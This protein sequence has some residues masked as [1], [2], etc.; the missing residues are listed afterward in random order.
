M[1]SQNEDKLIRSLHQKKFRSKHEKFIVEGA[2][3]IDYALNN[4]GSFSI[5]LYTKGFSNKFPNLIKKIQSLDCSLISEKELKKLSPSDSPSGIIGIANK[6]EYSEFNYDE[7]FIFLDKIADPGNM[8]TIIRTA[9]W[10]GISQ[11][12]L[13]DGCI[14]PFNSKVVRSAM[15]TH[16]SLKWIGEKP[17]KDFKNYKLIGADPKSN[18]INQLPKTN[19]KWGLIMGSE[20]HGISSDIYSLMNDTIAIPKI[21]EGESLNIGVAMGIL[22]YQLTK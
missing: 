8:G 4:N 21:G 6:I 7:N 5:I 17:I 22:L 10:F 13:S 11:I 16:F 15:G 14:D 9:S 18:N 2:R 12:A 20:A 3:S 1:I 19:H